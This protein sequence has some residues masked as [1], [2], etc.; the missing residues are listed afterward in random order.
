MDER[1]QEIISRSTKFDTYHDIILQKV[2][3][4]SRILSINCHKGR[5]RSVAFAEIMMQELTELGYN[6]ICL[7]HDI[8]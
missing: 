5:H 8:R 4:G 2:T 7:H 6:V 3:D 1:L